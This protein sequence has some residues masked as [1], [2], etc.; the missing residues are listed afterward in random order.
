MPSDYSWLRPPLGRALTYLLLCILA[1]VASVNGQAADPR[2]EFLDA[3]GQFSLALDGTFGDE[4]RALTASL[5]SM[6]AALARWDEAI[7]N[8][9]RGM[10]A[11]IGRAD[12]KLASR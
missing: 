5:D 9:E 2:A 10:A 8:S 11:D 7:V 12:P 3:L 1:P 4:G 6:A